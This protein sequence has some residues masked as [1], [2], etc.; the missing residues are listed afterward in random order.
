M[1]RILTVLAIASIAH[2]L[3]KAYCES[4]GDT[5]QVD[6]DKA[7]DWQKDSAVKGVEFHL[8][9][10][11]ATPENSHESW[12][13]QKQEEGWKYGP[14]KD[15]ERKEHPCFVPYAELP[16]AQK[17]KD[18]VFRAAVHELAPYLAD[19]NPGEGNLKDQTLGEGKP[20]FKTELAKGNVV[21]Q[22][23]GGP[24]MIVDVVFSTPMG[25]K[26]H[27]TWKVGEVFTGDVFYEVA[28][29]K[30]A[31]AVP[32]P[33]KEEPAEEGNGTM[34]GEAKAEGAPAPTLDVKG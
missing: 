11:D 9:N 20:T 8:T 32:E 27:C 19:A 21:M 2:E 29:H 17:A 6:W 7:P 12:L 13:K 22:K 24:K 28:L 31:D 33:A 1:K 18:Y 3:N 5:S 25:V 30:L 4:Q 26:A 15:V 10:P 14:V 23:V 16:E 34:S